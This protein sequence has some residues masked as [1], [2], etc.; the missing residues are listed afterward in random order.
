MVNGY[1]LEND[2]STLLAIR[3]QKEKEM[4]TSNSQNTVVMFTVHFFHTSLNRVILQENSPGRTP[5]NTNSSV[6]GVVLQAWF[7][8]KWHYTPSSE[9]RHA[10]VLLMYCLEVLGTQRCVF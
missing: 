10:A 1:V 5:W 2:L 7:G 4:L 3:Q 8:L 9:F 6:A